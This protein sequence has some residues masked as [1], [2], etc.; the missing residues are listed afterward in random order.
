MNKNIVDIGW[1]LGLCASA[2]AIGVQIIQIHERVTRIESLITSEATLCD[3]FNTRSRVSAL[4]FRVN[5]I[6]ENYGVTD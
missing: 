1:L 6:E 3:C 2:L 4:E 5:E